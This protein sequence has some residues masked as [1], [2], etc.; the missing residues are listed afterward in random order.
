MQNVIK[1]GAVDRHPELWRHLQERV[2]LSLPLANAN[3]ADR[4]S[5]GQTSEI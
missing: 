4:Q 1:D 2:L 3:V 5:D